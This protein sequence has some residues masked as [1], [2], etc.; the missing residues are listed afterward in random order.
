M[1]HVAQKLTAAFGQSSPRQRRGWWLISHPSSPSPSSELGVL[2]AGRGCV[3]KHMYTAQHSDTHD[4]KK[5]SPFTSFFFFLTME[6]LLTR[7]DLRVR[8]SPSA[9]MH[10]SFTTSSFSMSFSN[11]CVAMKPN[12]RH[13]QTTHNYNY[14]QTHTHACAHTCTHTHTHTCVHTPTCTHPHAHTH[15]HTHTHH[16]HIPYSCHECS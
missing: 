12:F 10:F 15:T 14:T 16:T 1:A 8:I 6:V 9:S 3:L 13:T 7:N 4:M 2:H 11:S 5:A